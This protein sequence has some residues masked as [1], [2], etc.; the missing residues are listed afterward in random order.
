MT[1][2]NKKT[3]VLIGFMASGK[4]R[5]GSLL[6]KR[7]NYQLLDLDVLIEERAGMTISQI[8]EERGEAHFRALEAQELVGVS[9]RDA[10]VIVTGGGTPT[11]FENAQ[12]LKKLGQ[13]FFLDVS[14]QK[15]LS[16]LGNSQERPLARNNV[17]QKNHTIE[18]LYY[19]RRPCY[20]MLGESIDADHGDE[21]IICD[22][23]I[24]RHESFYNLS[25]LHEV[26]LPY[27]SDKYTIFHAHGSIFHVKDI[28]EGLGLYQHKPVIITND[29]IKRLL[30][31]EIS[32]I[33]DQLQNR[34]SIISIADGES[35]K[36]LSTIE[37]IYQQLCEMRCLRN[38]LLI[39]LGGGVIGDMA[40]F[41]A[42][43]YMRGVP[44]IGVPTTLLAMVDS[45]IG[46]KTGVDTSFG[47]NLVG[48][49][50]NPRSVI[51][52]PNL[53]KSLPPEE[54]ACGMA[55]IIKHA[56]IA[57]ADL[58]FS[59]KDGQIPIEELIARAIQVKANIVLMDPLEKNI[60]AHL[61]L[62]HTFA[63]AIEKVS[64]YTIKHGQAVAM[65]LILATRLAKKMGVLEK[66]FI[67][68]LK[69]VLARFDLPT[70]MPQNI[71]IKDLI[72]AMRLD[73]KRDDGG[74]RFVLPKNVGEVLIQH[75]KEQ[76]ISIG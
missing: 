51:I 63:H 15:L 69:D 36:S 38:T 12:V 58:F 43:T 20:E 55:E 76:D 62:G 19:F 48:A 34:S 67:K 14:L 21:T 35:N 10:S 16:R 33:D 30:Q 65:G 39:A 71:H 18:E 42:K 31:K 2:A 45:S 22:E 6:A 1:T 28:I 9:A 13:V 72:P 24:K 29:N 52:D 54:F 64:D 37:T 32:A 44:F 70:D 53:L 11:F 23:I 46:G 57:D 47:K 74:L 5:I 56:M 3:I 26:E 7:L 50:N 66:D 40:G 4:S 68:D 49:F 61:N 73:K 17:N 41:V 59:L 75:V 60:R 8:F 27:G 25:H